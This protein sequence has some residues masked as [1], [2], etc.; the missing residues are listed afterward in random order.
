[1]ELA[2]YF[3]YSVS[4]HVVMTG[5]P[6]DGLCVKSFST[7]A[8]E[9][10]NELAE[11]VGAQY[12]RGS[13][14]AERF[15]PDRFLALM[16]TKL[17]E[18][19]GYTTMAYMFSASRPFEILAVSRPIPLSGWGKAFPSGLSVLEEDAKI[20]I[21]YGVADAESRAMLLSRSAL[22]DLFLWH[23]CSSYD[24]DWWRS[25][26]PKDEIPVAAAENASSWFSKDNFAQCTSA[27]E[28][29]VAQVAEATNDATLNETTSD[30]FLPEG[31]IDCQGAKYCRQETTE[32]TYKCPKGFTPAR[33]GLVNLFFVL[34]LC[35]AGIVV[36]VMSVRVVH[37]GVD[38]YRKTVKQDADPSQT[39]TDKGSLGNVSSTGELDKEL[40]LGSR[41]KGLDLLWFYLVSPDDANATVGPYS[42][43][44]VCQA[45]YGGNM[46]SNTLICGTDAHGIDPQ[47]EGWM[48]VQEVAGLPPSEA[49][50][51]YSLGEDSITEGPY[52]WSVLA[53][54]YYSGAVA[55][56]LLMSNGGEWKD[57]RT[58]ME[59][60]AAEATATEARTW[61]QKSAASALTVATSSFSDAGASDMGGAEKHAG[62][63]V[64][65]TDAVA[66]HR[67]EKS[68]NTLM[69]EDFSGNSEKKS[70]IGDR[71]Q[72]LQAMWYIVSGDPET[73]SYLGPYQGSMIYSWVYW[74]D[75][76]ADTMVAQALASP[77]ID[78]L[79]GSIQE[80][81]MMTASR[82]FLEED[83]P[84]LV[85]ETEVD[86][87]ES[88]SVTASDT[89]ESKVPTSSQPSFFARLFLC[90]KAAN[91]KGK[92]EK[93]GT[94]KSSNEEKTST[95]SVENENPYWGVSD[96][97]A[98]GIEMT[99][100]IASSDDHQGNW[101][102]ASDWSENI[103]EDYL[104]Y[105]YFNEITGATLWMEPAE[106]FRPS[107][108]QM[109]ID[110]DS[111]QTYFSHWQTGEVSWTLPED[112]D[113][114]D[115]E[116]TNPLFADNQRNH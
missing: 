40:I 73:C 45:L 112:D 106:G 13:A 88:K 44:D 79:G 32:V 50:E 99:T 84:P 42:K 90:G 21:T 75:V 103:D 72:R 38:R 80:H 98:V 66:T 107:K 19:T 55:P 105:Y 102:H 62:S 46:W 14:T 69:R 111:G 76:A 9:P 37:V 110:E 17:T 83:P 109:Q 61:A 36:I 49:P 22:R 92:A 115:P 25:A 6:G 101:N 48:E 96:S 89:D 100:V 35:V 57:L 23:G 34:M 11:K 18:G 26:F 85:N 3:V 93:S 27:I 47:G 114:A 39:K 2:T 67:P 52:I 63:S 10:L 81:T 74:E 5:R 58:F 51:W 70:V 97:A 108:W 78:D 20:L 1:M 8:F 30:S 68:I 12:I 4:P 116:T 43:E 54:W 16:H 15:G 86:G 56:D 113:D 31:C 64:Q 82:A 59:E 87:A 24:A 77:N 7:T 91:K 41:T 28:W 29:D 94:A 95:A 53:G 71:D 104:T 60:A 33:I 65:S